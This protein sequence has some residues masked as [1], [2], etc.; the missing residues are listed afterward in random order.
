[1][2]MKIQFF[3]LLLISIS[4]LSSCNNGNT[5]NEKKVKELTVTSIF[6]TWTLYKENINGKIVDHSGRP[7]AVSLKF[8]KNGYYILFDKITD[9]K[10]SDSGVDAIQERYKGQYEWKDKNLELT[11]FM[12]D[13]V[14][15]DV[16]LI[17]SLTETELVLEN[18]STKTIQYY[19]K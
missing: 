10:I 12:D 18:S 8:E 15:V 17:Q 14:I 11:H 2:K 19:K 16:Y 7:T 5:L 4:I 6:G 9:K 13:S 1:M 3:A